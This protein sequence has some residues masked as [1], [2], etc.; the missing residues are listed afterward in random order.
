LYDCF[1]AR[2]HT[3]YDYDEWINV[4]PPIMFF[5]RSFGH[6]KTIYQV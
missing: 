1:C 2:G 6:N 4:Y 3:L 5:I